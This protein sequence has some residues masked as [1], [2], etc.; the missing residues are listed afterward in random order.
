MSERSIRARIKEK[1]WVYEEIVERVPPFRWLPPTLD[2]VAQLLLVEAVGIVAFVYFQMPLDAALF[3][4]LAI[5]YTVVWSAG[6]LNI[7]PWVRRLKD[8]TNEQELKVLQAYKE[9]LLLSRPVEL[10]GGIL[11]FVGVV[12]ILYFNQDV[13]QDFLGSGFGNPLLFALVGVLAWD[14]SYRLG[15]SFVTTILAANRSV[16]L[17]RAAHR[18]RGLEYTAYSEVQTLKSLDLVNL[19]WGASAVLLLPIASK[20]PLLFYGLLAFLGAILGFSILSLL[21]METVPWLPPDVEGI[22]HHERFAY[23]ALCSKKQTHVTPVVFVY[24]GKY[25][26]F[27]ISV[28]SAKYRILKENDKV[29]ALVDLRDRRNPMNNRAVML[30]GRAMI[31]GEITLMGLLRLFV[32]GIWMF[33][34]RSLFWKK[35]PL[36]MNYYEERTYELPLAWQNKPFLSRLMVRIAVEKITYWRAAKPLPLRV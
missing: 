35:Y 9:R 24:D 14:I 20:L 25:L 11:C 33:W 17:N 6:C 8:P 7:I 36:Y 13:L 26:Y 1:K 30:R 19:Y 12:T 29:A 28:A 34:V 3:G 23:V 16:R 15:L 32:Y 27:A 21:M 2:V 31:L 4:S 22:L 5:V 10:A 18:R